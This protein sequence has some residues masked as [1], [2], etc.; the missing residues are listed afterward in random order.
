MKM[1]AVTS[2]PHLCCS[3]LQRAETIGKLRPSGWWHFIRGYFRVIVGEGRTASGVVARAAPARI[4]F[5][6][7]RRLCRLVPNLLI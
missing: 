6:T 2:N 3:W 7:L 5:L 4:I 1:A